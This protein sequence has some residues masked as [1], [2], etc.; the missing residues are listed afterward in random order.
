MGNET[1]TDDPVQT[2]TYAASTKTAVPTAK[3][4]GTREE[5]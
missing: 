4:D 2:A 5:R 1:A 3:T